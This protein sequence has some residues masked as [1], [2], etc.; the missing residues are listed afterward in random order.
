MPKVSVIVPVYN[1]AETLERCVNSILSQSEK[2]LELILVND[3]S[4]DNSLEL[5]HALAEKDTRIR[6]FSQK[7]SGVSVARNRGILKSCG[8]YLQ[9]ADSD[10][11]LDPRATENLVRCMEYYD[12]DLVIAGFYRVVKDK[13]SYKCAIEMATPL[14]PTEFAEFF[15]QEP[16]NFFYGVMWNKLYRRDLVL[17]NGIMC[18]VGRRWCE[19]F[20]FNLAYF[21]VCRSFCALHC[22]VYYY[23]KNEKGICA[24]LS[25]GFRSTIGL[26]MEFWDA[27]KDFFVRVGLYEKHKMAIAGFFLAVARD[28]LVGKKGLPLKAQDLVG[29]SSS[30]DTQKDAENHKETEGKL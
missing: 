21:K 22:P 19:D 6:V 7:N 26:R 9:F 8:K 28:D 12:V 25:L 10:D 5:C 20:L 23:I 16:A 24:N 17:N 15:M 29:R 11:Y 13:M 3:G 1:C 18:E 30:S 2:D 27:Y 14:T 4:V